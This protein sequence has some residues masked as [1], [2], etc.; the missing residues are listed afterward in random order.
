MVNLETSGV[1]TQNTLTIATAK[2]ATP[3]RSTAYAINDKLISIK[4]MLDKIKED[5]E[6]SKN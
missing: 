6:T 4:K 2:K 3:M 1:Y 5:Y